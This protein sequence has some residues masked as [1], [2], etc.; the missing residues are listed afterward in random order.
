M[1]RRRAHDTSNVECQ[2]DVLRHEKDGGGGDD[3]SRSRKYR[4]YITKGIMRFLLWIVFFASISVIYASFML[5]LGIPAASHHYNATLLNKGLENDYKAQSNNPQR[6]MH[7]ASLIFSKRKPQIPRR[8]IF[9]YK[10]NL[11]SPS[12]YD[13]PFDP[14]DPLTAN[15]LKTIDIYTNFWKISDM[16]EMSRMSHHGD[17]EQKSKLDV[18]MSSNNT[19]VIVSFLS[20]A[21]CIEVIEKSESRLVPH[22]QKETRGEFK[23]DICR[24]A[25]LY[26][27][28]GYYFDIDIGVVAPINFDSIPI[29]SEH[30]IN[31]ALTGLKERGIYFQ[32]GNFADEDS[33]TT[34][35]SVYNKAGRL[36]QAFTAAMPQHPVLRRALEY[37]V[38]Y[39]EGY[40]EMVLPHFVLENGAN[41]ANGLPSREN[42]QGL[43]AG[44]LTLKLALRATEEDEWE[45]FARS[46][47]DENNEMFSVGANASL[48]NAV[49]NVEPSKRYSRFLYEISLEDKL[50]K[51]SGIFNDIP[52][53]DANYAKKVRWCNFVCFEGSQVYFYSRVK[54]SKGCPLEK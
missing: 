37:L 4:V 42:P 15:V 1:I 17:S 36:F 51:Q 20:D 27:D 24:V 25:A 23:A 9:T 11:I 33:F 46:L 2:L 30:P 44:P 7:S 21:D 14:K 5:K 13:P 32:R 50:V 41:Y 22:F 52:L 48:N 43:G 49:A 26:L 18:T 38:A 28:G 47:L 54:G 29:Q 3:R 10:H 39:Y 16:A 45:E 34:F 53:Q 8:L 19:K 35:A 12:I 40:L 31:D 6:R